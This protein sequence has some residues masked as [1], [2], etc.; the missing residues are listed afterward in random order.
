VSEVGDEALE[1]AARLSPQGIPVVVAET[2]QQALDLALADADVVVLDGPCQTRPR[3]ASLSL[4]VVD[5]GAP[6]GAG[7]CPPEGD[8][9]APKAVLLAAADRVVG[10]GVGSFHSS[11][12]FDRATIASGGAWLGGRLLDWNDLRSRRIGLLTAM[13][14]PERVEAMLESHGVRPAVAIHGADHRLS[15]SAPR[16]CGIE[17]WLCTPKARTHMGS[18]PAYTCGA[19]V[20]TLD[21]SLKFAGSLERALLEAASADRLTHA[22]PPHTLE[23]G[24]A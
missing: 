2:R 14:R 11:L 13:A 17:L 6:W 12:P 16:S 7:S 23:C 5:M 24:V 20:A 18:R 19:P 22:P 10:I 1:C 9:R 3:R 21:F 15:F 8:L 4:L